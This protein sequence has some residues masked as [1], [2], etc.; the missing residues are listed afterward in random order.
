LF[1]NLYLLNYLPLFVLPQKHDTVKFG[2]G[3]G[4]IPYISHK[5][6]EEEKDTK[7]RE[8]EIFS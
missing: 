6:H 4:F 2:R 8:G 7:K 3:Q 5:G 1:G